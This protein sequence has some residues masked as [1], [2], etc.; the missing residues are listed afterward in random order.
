MG[1]AHV[2]C[3]NFPITGAGLTN[4]SRMDINRRRQLGA[5]CAVIGS[6]VLILGTI[7]GLLGAL[8][9]VEASRGFTGYFGFAVLGLTLGVYGLFLIV[10]S[11]RRR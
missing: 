6:I 11:S 3:G 8:H 4:G 10:S 2:V 7:A 5:Q 9:I 1:C